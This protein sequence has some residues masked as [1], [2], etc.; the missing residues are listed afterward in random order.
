MRRL[1]HRP[2][3]I[4]TDKNNST[5]INKNAEDEMAGPVATG[6]VFFALLLRD[7]RHARPGNHQSEQ[8]SGS[9]DPRQI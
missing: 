8:P 3:A 1:R 5:I 4:T 2:L 6:P 9:L 7:G